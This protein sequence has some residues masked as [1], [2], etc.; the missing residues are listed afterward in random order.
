MIRITLIR[1]PNGKG[2]IELFKSNYGSL[3]SL[4]KIFKEKKGI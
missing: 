2:L 4:K 1:T 3:K